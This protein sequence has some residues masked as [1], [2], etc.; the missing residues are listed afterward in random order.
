MTTTLLINALLDPAVYPHE[1]SHIQL[2]ETHIS[3]IILTGE[4]AYK[5][6]KPVNLG[7]LDFSTLERRHHYCQQ[8]LTLNRRLA[9]NIYLD[10]VPI[11]GTTDAPLLNATP[12]IEYAIKM[13]QFPQAQ[14][15]DKLLTQNKLLPEHIDKP[16]D[17]L[18][19][20]H[21]EAEVTSSEQPYG[22][23][24]K[25]WEPVAENFAQIRQLI[26]NK[27]DMALLQNIEEWSKQT[28]KSQHEALAQRKTKGYIRNCHG[29]L[30]L[31]NIALIDGRITPFDCIEFNDVFRWIDVISEIA[32][33]MMDLIERQHPHYAYRLLDRYLQTSGD[34]SGLAVLPFYLTYRAMV[35][36][37]VAAIRS[38]QDGLSNEGQA[39]AI[40]QFRDYLQLAKQFTQTHSPAL[41]ITCGT[42]GSGKTLL[43]QPLLEQHGL[44]R[45]R[46]D[47]ER[48]R[49]YGYRPA[50]RTTNTIGGNIYSANASLAT[51]QHLK[52]T[53]AQLL[54]NGLSV[55]VDA[56]FIKKTQREMFN[57][58]ARELELPFVIL[59]FHAAPE[60][61]KQWIQERKQEGKDASEATVEVL[62]HQLRSMEIPTID[63]A[64]H[65]IDIDSSDY[66]ATQHLLNAV[67]NL[68]IMKDITPRQ[69]G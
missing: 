46:S 20:F 32:F 56:T 35:R 67:E 69:P 13:K 47:V 24:E 40:N 12:A 50:D 60:L 26:T 51:Y 14:Q 31:A 64:D 59:H 58:L 7:F 62:E 61:L 57:A 4:Y 45:L 2:I 65:L 39:Q 16:T 68:A 29:D 38:Q 66:S 55:I 25:V 48:K 21:Q 36:A 8:E 54:T 41:F 18:T 22:S 10:I 19:T 17:A 11:G 1:T 34:Y 30:H 23:C 15:L 49:L 9:T 37:K 43:S 42:S 33:T 5:I 53:A 28:F 27:E 63:E 3:W 6:K 52:E 44:V